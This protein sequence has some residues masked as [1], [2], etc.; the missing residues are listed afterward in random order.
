MFKRIVSFDIGIRNLAYCVIETVETSVETPSETSEKRGTFSIKD[1]DI[2]SLCEKSEKVKEVPLQVLC[3]RM[4]EKLSSNRA[5][6]DVDCVVLE[7]QPS[8]INPKMKSI[9]MMLFTFFVHRGIK[10]VM[11]FAPRQKLS[12]Y[13]GPPVECHLKSKYSRTKFLGISYCRHMIQHLPLLDFFNQHKKKDDLADSLL[14]GILFLM[15][16]NKYSCYELI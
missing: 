15:K 1:W 14:Q 3:K 2:I 10:D 7:N 6:L 4:G 5:L 9:Q 13:K 11:M 8:Y 12:V 16:K